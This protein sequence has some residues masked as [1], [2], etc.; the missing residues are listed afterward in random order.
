MI[1]LEEKKEK[2]KMHFVIGD[3]GRGDIDRWVQLSFR[4][5]SQN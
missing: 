4:E 2:N 5:E 1:N 3:L